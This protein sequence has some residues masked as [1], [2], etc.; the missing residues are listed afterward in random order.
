MFYDASG[1]GQNNQALGFGKS[2]GNAYMAWT[3]KKVVF[4]DIAGTT[5]LSKILEEAVDS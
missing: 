1:W 4:D 2:Q 5:T 3:K